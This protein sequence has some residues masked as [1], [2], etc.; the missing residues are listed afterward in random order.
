MDKEQATGPLAGVKILDMTSVLLGPYATQI[1]GDLGAEVIKV[2]DPNGGDVVRWGG[3]APKT[4]GMGP[5]FVTLNRN[6]RSIGLDLRKPSAKKAFKKL[7][8]WA[9]VF[10]HNVRPAG[11]ARLGFDYD[12]V[13]EINPKL[14]YVHAAGFHA[15]GPYAGLQAF[16]DLVQ[17]ASGMASLFS[18]VDGNPVPRYMPALVA[19]KTTGLHAVYAVLAGLFHRERSG[20]GQFIEVP[21]FES[22]V[23]FTLAEHLF[24]RTFE[25]PTGQMGYVRV[26]N[27]NRKPYKTKDGY[28]CILPY[29]DAQW[30]TFFKLGGRPDIMDDPRFATFNDRTRNSIALYGLI[31]DVAQT[32]TTAEWLEILKE[33]N[34]PSMAVAEIEDLFDDPHL[35][36]T[37]FFQKVE[38]PSEG[39]YYAMKHP[40]NF[41]KTP[42]ELR[43][44]A[45]QL[46][47]H[48]EE[49]LREIGL[50]EEDIQELDE[51]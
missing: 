32:K 48:T 45:P 31:E 28:I 30:I 11:M 16:D 51:A 46:G 4:Q 29:S 10:I 21:M 27:P 25:P 41:E 23:G 22:M 9:D 42:A 6:K 2:E 33:A 24:G 1:L 13:K 35:K 34:V 44:H 43:R 39:T 7:L 12:R 47:E 17:G 5:I 38:H 26:L 50:S 8:Q 36:E 19:D 37:G 18:K 20:E 14:L 49:V 40:V 3:E 15:D